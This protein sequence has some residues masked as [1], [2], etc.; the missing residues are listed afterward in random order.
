MEGDN[1]TS[2]FENI[3]KIL[4]ITTEETK[5]ATIKHKINLKPKSTQNYLELLTTNGY[6]ER[7]T[8][9]P[10]RFKTTEY[11]EKILKKTEKIEKTI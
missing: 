6:I 4:S 11:G 2:K 8:E 10:D 9:A 3:K 7:T 5:K 1:I